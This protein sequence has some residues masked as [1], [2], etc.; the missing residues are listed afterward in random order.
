MSLALILVPHTSPM[1][2]PQNVPAGINSFPPLTHPLS[3]PPAFSRP[4]TLIAGQSVVSLATAN[5]RPGPSASSMNI[6]EEFWTGGSCIY[7]FGSG[8]FGQ[9]GLGFPESSKVPVMVEGASAYRNENGTVIMG[10][11]IVQ[12]SAGGYHTLML[13]LEGAAYACGDNSNGQLGVGAFHGN[14][15][16]ERQRR[17]SES[18]PCIITT[19][20]EGAALPVMRSVSAGTVCCR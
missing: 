20:S 11:P 12:C 6:G 10:P 13:D 9:L 2:N 5:S 14:V 7:S 17:R 4:T 16:G 3:A 18:H 1:S 15:K 8:D 19:D